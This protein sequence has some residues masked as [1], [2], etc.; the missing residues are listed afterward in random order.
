MDSS[1]PPLGSGFCS[2]T[3]SRFDRVYV[4]I[5]VS[6]TKGGFTKTP[7]IMSPRFPLWDIDTVGIT[8]NIDIS[9]P[10]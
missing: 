5:T 7:D 2:L 1:L 3:W 8:L 10:N 6:G 9:P 4:P